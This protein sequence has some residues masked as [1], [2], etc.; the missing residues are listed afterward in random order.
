MSSR[1]LSRRHFLQLTAAAAAGASISKLGYGAAQTAPLP[2]P[3]SLPF[4]AALAGPANG[5]W[6]R[7]FLDA[8]T[9]EASQGLN[10]VFHAA[11]KYPGN[12]VLKGDNPW[13]TVP[14]AIT[15]PYVY[16]T[17]AWVGDK[18]CMWY[19]I[20]TKGN[21]V[22]YAESR[23]GIHWTKPELG[24]V[25]FNGSKANNLSASASVPGGESHN[26]SVLRCPGETD[27][28][29]RYAL[30]AFDNKA[31]HARVAFSPD[32]LHW[33]YL[34]E[35]EKKPLFSSSDVVNFFYDPY[36]RRYTVTWK[37]R[38]RRG[39]AVG[40]GWS[41]DGLVWKKPY[42][43]ALF[44]ADD[45]DPDAT[46]IYGMPVFP[47]QGL[48]LGLP[49]MYNA[50]YFK[51]G[52]YSV[53]KLHEAQEGSPRTMEVQLAWSWDLIN[54]TR[55]PSRQQFIPRGAKGQWDAGMIVTA[56]APV[57]VGDKLYFYYGGC[58][59]LHDDKRVN[60]AI[61]L[62]T[63]RL[64]GFC[65]MRA[66]DSEGW[67][68]GRRDPFRRPAV[69]INARTGKEGYVMAEVLDRRDRVVPGFSKDD[70][71]A[72]QGDSVRHELRW[73]T[74]QFA[75]DR[76]ASD[77]KLRFRLKNADLFSYLPADLDPNEP[78]IARLREDKS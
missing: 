37:T 25:D 21:H 49:W 65:S 59:G 18:L 33:T 75:A 45:L 2:D 13:E 48:Y 56:R 31:G 14:A 30:Y 22:G 43:G 24:I 73:K 50:R 68:I 61:G 66:G 26:P 53:K 77:Y 29:K 38:S 35:T 40:L 51:S 6:R 20:L 11:E 41:E 47:Y 42:D 8:W 44:A 62:A 9:V 74:G 32:G 3:S 46:Q 60:A 23:D 54:W 63:L 72:F 19:Q 55:E 70:C 36:R 52:D 71:V 7:L 28:L 12:P 57:I 10:R 16:G 39:R 1:P 67:L 27:P 69:T 34:P 17:V 64:D 58:D 78:D 15:G 5:P 4:E 76:R